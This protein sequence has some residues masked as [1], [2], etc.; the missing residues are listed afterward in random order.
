MISEIDYDETGRGAN[1]QCGKKENLLLPSC[2]PCPANS[3]Q[4]K[5][6]EQSGNYI[7]DV[8]LNVNNCPVARNP[9]F[10]WF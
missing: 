2:A 6:E 1:C 9:S 8:F 3:C 10:T 4:G 5:Q 7:E